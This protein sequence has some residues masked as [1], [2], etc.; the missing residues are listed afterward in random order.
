MNRRL[1]SIDEVAEA[2]AVSR[3]TIIRELDRGYMTS[4]KIESRRLVPVSEVDAYLAARI[5][6]RSGEVK[7]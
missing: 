5:P 7:R 3:R 6:K 2:L 4:V 1:Y